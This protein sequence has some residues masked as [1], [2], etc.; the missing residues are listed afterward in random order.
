VKTND[1]RYEYYAD[2]IT[3][4][5]FFWTFIVFAGAALMLV[6]HSYALTE[7]EVVSFTLL[8]S[9]PF[10]AVCPLT[11]LE[12]RLRRKYD[13]SYRNDGSYLKVYLNK[14]FSSHLTTREVNVA[15]GIFYTLI[16]ATATFLMVKG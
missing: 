4:I 12:E 9:L 7:I 8:I 15:V 5:H 13:P 10:G 3:A 16:Y 2:G 11:L 1:T 6:W 14:I